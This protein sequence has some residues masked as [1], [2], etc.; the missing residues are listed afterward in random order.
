MAAVSPQEKKK[1]KKLPH[2]F[3]LPV[4]WILSHILKPNLQQ[5][6][7]HQR[8]NGKQTPLLME[9]IVEVETVRC[10]GDI[11]ALTINQLCAHPF[12]LQGDVGGEGEL[13]LVDAS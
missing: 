8:G 9:G 2:A 12:S 6:V 11:M 10:W 4:K 7:T 13:E 1:E 3:L 5:S